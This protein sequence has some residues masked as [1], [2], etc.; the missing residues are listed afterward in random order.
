MSLMTLKTQLQ[1]THRVVVARIVTAHLTYLRVPQPHVRTGALFGRWPSGIST[2]SLEAVA[3][4]RDP[5]WRDHETHEANPFT[6]QPAYVYGWLD[7]LY[8]VRYEL[9][10]GLKAQLI[11][12]W[13]VLPP[14]PAHPPLDEAEQLNQT[15]QREASFL[16]QVRDEGWLAEPQAI[17]I[18]REVDGQT[19]GHMYAFDPMGDCR[20]LKLDETPLSRGPGGYPMGS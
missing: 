8:D 2:L 10:P 7:A 5:D 19:R 14:A 15:R 9:S 18:V 1:F 11:G 3:S 20:Q 13:V 4:W 17:L 12:H 6:L 16:Q